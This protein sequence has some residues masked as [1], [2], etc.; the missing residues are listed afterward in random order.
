MSNQNNEE[1]VEKKEQ[2]QSVIIAFDDGSQAIFSGKAVCYPGDNKRVKNIMFTT[3]KDLP[4]G[5]NFEKPGQT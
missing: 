5:F 4:E 2:M 3:P 1:K